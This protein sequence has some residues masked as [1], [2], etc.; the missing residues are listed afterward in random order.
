MHN[1]PQPLSPIRKKF[2]CIFLPIWCT[3]TL[4]P[5]VVICVLMAMHGE[6]KYEPHILIWV[7]VTLG[8]GLTCLGIF[9]LWLNRKECLEREL[10]RFAYLFKEPKPLPKWKHWN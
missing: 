3:A 4:I 10:K 9:L 2:L 8:T 6:E 5:L 1:K 7:A